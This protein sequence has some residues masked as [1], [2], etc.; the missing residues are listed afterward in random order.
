MPDEQPAPDRSDPNHTSPVQLQ[1]E[2]RELTHEVEEL[3]REGA[4]KSERIEELG[5]RARY[6]ARELES[7]THT[8]TLTDLPNR[9]ALEFV[10]AQTLSRAARRGSSTVA[11][12]IGA[13]ETKRTNESLG[14]ATGDL[15]LR[16]M[17]QRMDTVLRVEDTLCRIGGDEFFAL[18]AETELEDGVQVGERLRRA[19]ADQPLEVD[20][21]PLA[22][23]ASIAV[24]RIPSSVVSLDEVLDTMRGA[25]AT[26]KLEGPDRVV[27]ATDEEGAHTPLLAT[28]DEFDQ[29]LERGSMRVLAQSVRDLTTGTVSGYEMLSRGPKGP[30][31]SP[32][33]L[34]RLAKERGATTRLDLRCFRAC[35][36]QSRSIDPGL[37][38][39]VNLMPS[40]LVDTPVVRLLELFAAAGGPRRF[41]IEIS[42]QQFFGAPKYLYEAVRE[43]KSHG[44]R[45]AIDDVGFGRSSLESLVLLEPDVIKIARECV[46]SSDRFD[47]RRHELE[48]LVRAAGALAPELV[49]EGIE[50][51]Q[52]RELCVELGIQFGQGYLWDKPQ[53]LEALPAHSR[54]LR[55]A[56]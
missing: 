30:Y 33:D 3:R 28:S 10:L 35:V 56:G 45:I 53:E 34:F 13:D 55:A 51:P 54:A 26:S 40:T 11:L 27:R 22:T 25:L 6:L 4:R 16:G 31:E 48:R 9:R 32:I 37:R 42:E 38:V 36:E 39:N 46:D 1:A 29:L 43:L 21:E 24:A 5:A 18:L 23:T 14:H 47:S 20:G 49:A 50:R 2:L 8:D 52:E 17:A 15:V 12:L 19:I 44:V 41:C 7:Q